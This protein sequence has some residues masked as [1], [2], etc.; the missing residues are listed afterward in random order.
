MSISLLVLQQRTRNRLESWTF[1][2]CIFYELRQ[3]IDFASPFPIPVS[4]WVGLVGSY[5]YTRC[6]VNEIMTR[7]PEE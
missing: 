7:M 2:P 3:D 6:H 4:L 5:L 1:Q